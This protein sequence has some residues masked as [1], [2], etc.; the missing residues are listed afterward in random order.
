MSISLCNVVY[1]LVTKGI[2]NGIKPFLNG[3]ISPYQSSFILGRNIHHNIIIS[4]EMV[5][6][7]NQIKRQNSFHVIKID[8]KKKAHYILNWNFINQCLDECKFPPKLAIIIMQ[9]ITSSTFQILCNGDNRHCF[10]TSRGI[11]QG[12][13]FSPYL[14][15]ICVDRL[16]HI[17]ANQVEVDYWKPMRAGREGPQISHLL[18]ADDLLLFVE[19]SVEQDYCI[20][21][22]LNQFCSSSGQKINN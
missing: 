3:I 11:R 21:H 6:A 4:L 19:A 7:M 15:I 10:D 1:K 12:D 8:L 16:S 17:I 2:V 18:F 9:C 20:M 13:P 22:C 5:H 14:F